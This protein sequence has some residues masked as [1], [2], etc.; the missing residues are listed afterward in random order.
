MVGQMVPML[1]VAFNIIITIN[2]TIISIIAINVTTIN[3][4][5]KITS[6]KKLSSNY[7]YNNQT[8]HLIIFSIIQVYSRVLVTQR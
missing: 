7:R 2:I 4:N 5:S 6:C 8:R 3:Y 1:Q